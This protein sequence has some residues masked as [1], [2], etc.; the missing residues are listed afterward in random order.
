MKLAAL[1]LLL[2]LSLFAARVAAGSAITL[3]LSAGTGGSVYGRIY[4]DGEETLESSLVTNDDPY[5]TRWWLSGDDEEVLYVLEVELFSQRDY[6]IVT[7]EFDI[8]IVAQ[9]DGGTEGDAG[10]SEASARDIAL[11]QTLTGEVGDQ[12]ARDT[13]RLTLSEA[14]A[15]LLQGRIPER[16]EGDVRM[17]L[18]RDGAELGEISSTCSW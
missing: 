14:T 10:D 15:L 13:Y 17:S 6:T 5:E 2:C 11:G 4:R 12:D 7:Y 16:Q 3:R 18:W 9:Q 8:E 1:P